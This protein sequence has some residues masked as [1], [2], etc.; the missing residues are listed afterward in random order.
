[1]PWSIRRES[2]PAVGSAVQS[3]RGGDASLHS[4]H[5]SRSR[6]RFSSLFGGSGALDTDTQTRSRAASSANAITTAPSSHLPTAMSITSV[7]SVRSRKG[8]FVDAGLLAN[9]VT[10]AGGVATNQRWARAIKDVKELEA[11]SAP[12]TGLR[13]VWEEWKTTVRG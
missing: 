1:M 7:K 9:T 12:V 10:G 8:S 3:S 11:S 13:G 4:Q 2:D 6:R 5:T